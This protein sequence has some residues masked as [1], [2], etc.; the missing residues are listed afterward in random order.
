[1]N[2]KNLVETFEDNFKNY[3]GTKYAIGTSMGRTALYSILKAIDLEENDEVIIPAYICEAVPNTVIKI[4]AVP[5]F[6]DINVNDYHISCSHLESLISKKT[7]VVIVNHTFGYPENID[8]IKSIISRKQNDRKIYL[9]E[10]V[11]HALGAEYKNHKL[12]SLGDAGFFS[13]TKNMVDI[14]GGVISTNNSTIA[15]N[16]RKFVN[17]SREISISNR[18][19]F[20]A[21]SF[22]DI[23]RINS[24]ISNFFMG[25]LEIMPKKFQCIAADYN[26]KFKIPDGASMSALQAYIALLQLD[27]LDD[28]NNKRNYNQSI[29]D[30]FLRN[31]QQINVLQ[32][33]IKD[34][35][36]VC[37]WYVIHVNK[38]N[39]RDEMINL[40]KNKH[41]YFSKFW[42]PLPIEQSSFYKQSPADVPN[43]IDNARSTIVFKI[44]PSISS[45]IIKSIGQT[46]LE[47]LNIEEY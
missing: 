34:S 18:L 38:S 17:Q 5:I 2:K 36:H 19:F 16:T 15:H 29:L 9:I 7:R 30:D 28:F 11:A 14:G 35:N 20:G 12:G 22:F 43:A 6:V 23:A 31:I 25:I 33:Y 13:L 46:I 41:I 27:R 32:P 24:K 40:C 37:T 3:I 21:L 10:D 42:D 45:S 44:S 4:G 26:E 8:E 39:I 1:M 47:L